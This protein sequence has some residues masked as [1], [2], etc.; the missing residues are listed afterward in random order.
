MNR[1]KLTS[2]FCA[3]CFISSAQDST[4]LNFDIR[5][6]L[7]ITLAKDGVTPK[8]GRKYNEGQYSTLFG[9]LWGMHFRYAII[10]DRKYSIETGYMFD[11]SMFERSPVVYSMFSLGIKSKNCSMGVMKGWG[12]RSTTKGRDN[13]FGPNLHDDLTYGFYFYTNSKSTLSIR[14]WVIFEEQSDFIFHS[15]S[16]YVKIFRPYV[17][18]FTETYLGKGIGIMYPINKDLKLYLTKTLNPQSEE[19][20]GPRYS[21]FNIMGLWSIKD[22]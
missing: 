17:G 11:A 12:L 20:I 19:G 10:S 2:I 5:A 1:K 22:N 6:N 21:M 9:P 18:G 3:L 13:P 7:S 15:L 16:M 8:G 14:S 4:R